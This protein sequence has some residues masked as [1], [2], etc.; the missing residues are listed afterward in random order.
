[1]KIYLVGGAVRDRLLGIESKDLDYVVVLDQDKIV[2]HMTPLMGYVTMKEWMKRQGFEIFLETPEMFTIRA[3]FPKGHKHA[4]TV[5][6]FVLARKEIGYEPGTRRPIL[7]LGTLYDDLERRDFTINAMAE[8]EDGNLIDPF[9]GSTALKMKKLIT[10]LTPKMTFLDDPLRVL[11]AL[12]FSITKEMEIPFQMKEAM[13]FRS[14]FIKLRDVVSQ[15]RIREELEK[16]FR[17]DTEASMRLLID[18]DKAVPGL[19]NL[20][21][22]E[23]MWLKP[24]T[25]KK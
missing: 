10:P 22:G 2:G 25:K 1:M 13:S 23:D 6:D 5:A 14:V 15:E 16:M 4:G 9:D 24:T 17:H 19:L 7:E 8:D 3:K 20:C 21:F 12:R 11:R 18:M